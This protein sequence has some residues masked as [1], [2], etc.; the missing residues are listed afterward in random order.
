MGTTS[1]EQLAR[2]ELAR[3]LVVAEARQGITPAANQ[4]LTTAGRRETGRPVDFIRYAQG[5]TGEPRRPEGELWA[6]LEQLRARDLLTI[7]TEDS[8]RAETE[9]L[10]RSRL[11]E[12]DD[13]A[14]FQVGFV[15]FTP[16]GYRVHRAIVLEVLGAAHVDY[17]DSFWRFDRD[18]RRFTVVAP[19]ATLCRRRIDE[20][21]RRGRIPDSLDP[22]MGVVDVTPPEPIGPWK[23]RRF[24][25][26]DS[27]Y[28]SV[29]TCG[30]LP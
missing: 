13:A 6:A 5:G 11:P 15:D 23:P 28:L 26:R 9:R 7:V 21:R 12:P 27:G 1:S 8:V 24:A 20:V 25:L 10:A 16:G 3:R 19:T 30:V 14:N 22:K 18:A 17:S 2:E 4:L 29:M